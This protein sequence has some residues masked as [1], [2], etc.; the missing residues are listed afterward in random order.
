MPL[1]I[2]YLSHMRMKEVRSDLRG[3]LKVVLLLA[4]LAGCS[5]DESATAPL[6]PEVFLAAFANTGTEEIQMEVDSREKA[7]RIVSLSQELGLED[8]PF[9]RR[10]INNSSVAYYFWQDQ[11]SSAR[12]KDLS[13]EETFITNDICDLS[14]ENDVE[15][16]IRRVSG[17]SSFVVMAYASFPGGGDPQFSL[18][19]LER[20]TGECR[21]LPVTDVNVSGIENYSIQGELMALYYFQAFTGTPL[22]TLV[23]LRSASVEETLI[24]DENFQAATFRGT[25]LWIFNKDAS[26]LVY[27]TQS[28]NFIRSGSAPGLPAQGPGMFESRFDGDQMLVQY[29]Y[30]QPSLFFAQPAVYDFDQSAIIQGGDPFLPEL[31]ERV[32]RETGDR[33]LFGKFAVDLPTDTI[34]LIYVRGNGAAEGGVVLTN[35]SREWLEVIPLPY[36]PEQVEIRN[37]R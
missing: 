24:V 19:I 2:L 25:D 10:D 6:A 17:T 23:N 32:E 22:I 3:Y 33:V 37:I 36:V 9:Y 5:E 7:P 21:D 26:Y 27:N 8:L 18:R 16:A 35:F 11:Q 31:Q 4:L 20:S 29:I 34:A 13:S 1:P 15:K 28:G 12:Y 30:Q 14:S